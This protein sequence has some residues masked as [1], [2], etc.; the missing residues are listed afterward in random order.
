MRQLNYTI[1]SPNRVNVE[2]SRSTTCYCDPS[3]HITYG[4]FCVP[5]K[6]LHEYQLYNSFKSSHRLF[7]DLKFYMMFCQLVKNQT[8]CQHLANLC[9][10]SFYNLNRNSP[11]HYLYT[12]Q[13]AELALSYG[14]KTRPFFFYRK[15]KFV[16]ELLDKAVDFQY[17]MNERNMV[18][19]L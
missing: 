3:S 17:D 15:G 5:Q 1:Y 16:A 2:V 8:A 10:L 18:S 13:T 7:R 6:L 11:C 9:V 4:D 19:H 14:D 12:T